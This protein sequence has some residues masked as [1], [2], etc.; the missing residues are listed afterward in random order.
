[1]H[2]LDR[3]VEVKKQELGQLSYTEKDWEQ[4]RRLPAGLSLAEALTASPTLSIIAEIKPA[5]PVKGVIRSEV[6]PV[7]IAKGYEQAGA[8]AISVLTDSS[9]FRAN[10]ENL[11][12]AKQAIHIPVLRKDFIIDPR[13]VLESKLLGADAILLIATILT[14]EE[15]LS[16][17]RLAHELNMEVLVE[18]YDESELERA[19]DCQPDV[20]GINNRNLTDFT[21]DI[22]NTEKIFSQIEAFI[23][24]IS[25]SGILSIEDAKRVAQI[26]VDGVLI[27]EYF[28]RHNRPEE[29]VRQMIGELT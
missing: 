15:L 20:L 9:F 4:A 19:L 12:R 28:M 14:R 26:G 29:A 22:E 11:V 16:L 7:T 13:Q 6:D 25:E 10:R 1:M 5:S 8:A 2:I 21:V 24:V 23:P 27:G 18:V 3:I 17:T